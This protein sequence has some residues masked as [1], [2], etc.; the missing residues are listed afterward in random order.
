MTLTAPEFMRRVLLHVLP[1]GFHRIR[2]F[3]FLGARHR[4]EKLARCRELLSATAPVPTRAA[5]TPPADYRDRTAALT[6][7]SLRVCPACHHGEMIIIERLL[8]T[9]RGGLVHPDTS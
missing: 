2:Y 4:R 1:S 8:P 7:I 6:G 3:G 5:A 9:R